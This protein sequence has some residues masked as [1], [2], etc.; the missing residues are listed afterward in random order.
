MYWHYLTPAHTETFGKLT[1]TR[2]D[3]PASDTLLY[4]FTD[5]V[6]TAAV[7]KHV[8]K[9]PAIVIDHRFTPR[10]A[11]SMRLPEKAKLTFKDVPLEGVL[12]G[13]AFIGYFEARFDK[14]DPVTLTIFVNGRRIGEELIANFDPLR[15]FEYTLNEGGTGTVRFEVHAP[16][17]GK[18]ELGLAADIRNTGGRR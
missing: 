3:K 16:D 11:V 12:R 15:P 17:N 13:Y 18:R 14:G 8:Q 2:F 6:D 1:V 4:D 9:K 10:R 5:H 7:S